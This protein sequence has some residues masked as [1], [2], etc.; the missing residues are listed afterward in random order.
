MRIGSGCMVHLRAEELPS[1]RLI[2]SVPR[3]LVAVVDGTIH[4]THDSSR[5]GARCV[6][7]YF[8]KRPA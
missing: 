5:A 4:D 6:Y 8:Q 2:V 1:G 3:H 7:G